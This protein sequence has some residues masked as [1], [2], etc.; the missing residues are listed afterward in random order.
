MYH[1]RLSDLTIL[2][3]GLPRELDGLKPVS[4]DDLSWV[5]APLDAK[6]AGTGFWPPVEDLAV[7]GEPVVDGAAKVVRVKPAAPP[8]PAPLTPLRF[9]LRLTQAER[10]AIRGSA[11]PVVVDFLDLLNHAQEVRVDDPNTVAGLGYMESAG[12]LD[13]GR[14]A[15]ILGQG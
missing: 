10:T 7:T 9:R 1:V 13:A 12:L 6:Y 14:A 8:P 11:D 5:G 3:H 15:A 2:G 4:L